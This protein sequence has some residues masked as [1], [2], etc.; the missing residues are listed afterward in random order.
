MFDKLLHAYNKFIQIFKL[1][2]SIKN[3]LIIVLNFHN[4]FSE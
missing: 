3:K 2:D 4:F 1:S